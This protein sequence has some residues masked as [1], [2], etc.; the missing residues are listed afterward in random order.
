[1]PGPHSDAVMGEKK[2][3]DRR[4][5]ERYSISCDITLLTPG[6]GRKR[7]I[8]QG[9]LIDINDRGARFESNNLLAVDDRVSLEVH[10][11]NPDGNITN[12]RFPGIVKRVSA[13]I[14]HEIAVSFLRGGSFVRRKDS[15]G[16]NSSV[17]RTTEKGN[18]V[19]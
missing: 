11:S 17:F 6:R 14:W 12:M 8:G 9:R 19:N 13:G 1:M 18:W 3:K 7:V 4:R 10:F 16:I 2:L 15:H 5:S